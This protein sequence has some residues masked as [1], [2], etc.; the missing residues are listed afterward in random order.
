MDDLE[1]VLEDVLPVARPVA[2]PSEHAHELLVELAT[3]RLEHGLLAGLHDV[4][5]ELGLCLVVHLLDPR[6]MDPAV[7]DELLEREPCDLAPQR[8]E[9]RQDDGMG[10]VV[11]DEV[12]ARQVLERADVPSLA[13]DDPALEI[14]RRELDHSDRRLGRVARRDA[15]ERV[16]DERASPTACVRSRLLL[17]LPHLP[18][19]LVSHEV[20]RTFDQLLPRFVHGQARDLL[21]RAERVALRISELFLK[22]LDVNLAIPE[23]L[24][25]ALELGQPRVDLEL[26]GEHPLL[27]LR[28]LDAPVLDLAFDL[29]PQRDGLLPRVDLSLAPHGLGLALRVGEQ[30]LAFAARR[31]HA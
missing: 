13:A 14:V 12:D 8:I 6:G 19:E 9:R 31:A 7:L 24:L 10:R 1:R 22:R 26:L 20:L 29:A 11:D 18:C 5:L 23:P 28:H 17:H 15:L 30:P 4:L 21:E 16:G 2:Q 3:V 27:D 25:L